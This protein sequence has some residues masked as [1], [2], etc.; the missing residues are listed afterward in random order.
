MQKWILS[1]LWHITSD[2]GFRQEQQQQQKALVILF[3]VRLL[4][5]TCAGNQGTISIQVF[6]TKLRTF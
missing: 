4:V 6:I 5:Q 3:K 2:I 1:F